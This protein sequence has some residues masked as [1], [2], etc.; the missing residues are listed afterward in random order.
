MTFH[1]FYKYPMVVYQKYLE[2][3]M[4]LDRFDQRPLVVQR[5]KIESSQ[6]QSLYPTYIL[7]STKIFSNTFL[8]QILTITTHYVFNLAFQIKNVHNVQFIKILEFS[9]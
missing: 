9:T 8:V 5:S 3:I 6:I 4:K 1:E 2:D 7:H